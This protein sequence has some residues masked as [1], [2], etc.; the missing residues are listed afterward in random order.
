MKDKRYLIAYVYIIIGFI[1]F[2]LGFAEIVDEYWSGMGSA[3]LVIGILRLIRRY[4]INKNEAYREKLEIEEKDERNH[5]IRNKAW[6]WAGYLYVMSMAVIT[7]ILKIVGQESLMMAT[8]GS[9]CLM[10]IFFWISYL[11]LRRKY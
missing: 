3:L 11:I 5:F 4:R 6:A 10:L 1:L 9:V 2:V 7:I 8:S